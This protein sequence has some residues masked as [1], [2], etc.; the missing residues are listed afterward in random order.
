MTVVQLT[1]LVTARLWGD[2]D[3]GRLSASAP[4]ERVITA[5]R[6]MSASPSGVALE[7]TIRRGPLTAYALLGATFEPNPDSDQL[8]IVA[9]EDACGIPLSGSLASPPET[10]LVGLPAEFVE[11]VLEGAT[12]AAGQGLI[13]AAGRLVFDRAAYGPIGS[14]GLLFRQI[15]ASVTRMLFGEMT[16]WQDVVREEVDRN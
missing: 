10:P 12:F 5:G 16:R 7:V 4:T 6:D 1:E 3:V 11:P 13:Q 14:S 2:A 9:L 8:L 15:A